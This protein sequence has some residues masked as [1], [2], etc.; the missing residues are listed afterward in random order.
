MTLNDFK[1]FLENIFVEFHILS[2]LYIRCA[3]VSFHM[4]F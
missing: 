2:M 1:M 3:S 4:Y